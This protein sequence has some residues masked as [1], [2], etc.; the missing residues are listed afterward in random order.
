VTDPVGVV[1]DSP[2]FLLLHAAMVTTATTAVDVITMRERM[3]AKRPE[4]I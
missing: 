1:G 2:L 3:R 4:C